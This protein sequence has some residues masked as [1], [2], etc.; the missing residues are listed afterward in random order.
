MRFR[1]VIVLA[2][3][4]CASG[5]L[6]AE[7]NLINNPGFEAL[8]AAAN[9]PQEAEAVAAARPL[10][11]VLTQLQE[12]LLLLSEVPTVYNNHFD[13]VVPP[14]ARQQVSHYGRSANQQD[15]RLQQYVDETA[16]AFCQA[17]RRAAG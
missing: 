9:L 2:V 3:L 10:S 15:P 8:D 12:A 14:A 11:E 4:S 7:A 16:E 13:V 17:R 5:L 1:P 6:A